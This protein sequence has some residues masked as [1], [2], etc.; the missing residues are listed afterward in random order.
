MVGIHCV[1]LSGGAI[2]VEASAGNITTIEDCTFVNNTAVDNFGGAIHVDSSS[3]ALSR[4]VFVENSVSS[5]GGVGGGLA[6]EC[7]TIV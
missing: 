7:V 5:V 2:D 6:S 1:Q 3:L 4:S